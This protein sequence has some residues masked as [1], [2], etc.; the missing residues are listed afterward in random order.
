MATKSIPIRRHLRRPD[1]RAGQRQHRPQHLCG[2]HRWW[3]DRAESARF[4]RQPRGGTLQDRWL[5][6]TRRER[7]SPRTM[8]TS[9][10]PSVRKTRS[11]PRV[12]LGASRHE[13]KPR[14][15]F[16]AG[17]PT[18]AGLLAATGCQAG[19]LRRVGLGARTGVA[20]KS[21]P[22]AQ[23]RYSARLGTFIENPTLGREARQLRVGL[24]RHPWEG[25]NS[26]AQSSTAITDESRPSGTSRAIFH[27]CRTSAR[28]GLQASNWVAHGARA[29]ADS[30][31]PIHT[32]I[33]TIAAT[34]G[35]GDRCRRTR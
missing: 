19:S 15:V 2:S 31:V 8:K 10:S 32:W 13:L 30:A 4:A 17:N 23:D 20:R 1:E 12:I 27:R 34:R 24:A 26:R 7:R 5:P 9:C 14:T 33:S 16:N 3:F 29:V 35:C 22:D 28:C 6:R 11:P 18:I 25:V 21:A